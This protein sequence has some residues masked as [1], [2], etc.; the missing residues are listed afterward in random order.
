M[1]NL[2][3]YFVWSEGGVLRQFVGY[4]VFVEGFYYGVKVAGEVF[5][6]TVPGGSAGLALAYIGSLNAAG[7]AGEVGVGATWPTPPLNS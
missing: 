2:R 4:L 7:G 3:R 5:H 6:G 1:L